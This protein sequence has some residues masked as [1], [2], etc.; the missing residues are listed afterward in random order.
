M[1]IQKCFLL[2]YYKYGDFDAVLHCFTRESGFQ[3]FFVKGIYSPRNRKKPYLTPL[4]LLSV[5]LH[6][7]N[8]KA[9]ATVSKI[10][11][12]HSEDDFGD[13]KLRT[14]LFFLADF[15]D[16]MLKRENENPTLFNE[17]LKVRQ[18]IS[19][20]NQDAYISFIVRFLQISGVAPL[21]GDSEFLNPQTGI[22][23]N[24][25][26][27]PFFNDELS[28]IWKQFLSTE[29]PY[30]IQLKRI[31]RKRF[32]DSVM[33]YYQVHFSDFRTPDSLEILREIYS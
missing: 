30:K 3:S 8:S 18:E 31:E 1:I 7:S 14:I 20:G 26:V 13:L 21:V 6:R 29:N 9:I 17:I 15:L 25:E 4:N 32:T 5:T 24:K 10:E 23:T 33:I 28:L 11:N 19:T 12:L 22:F 2:S 27:H 16:Q